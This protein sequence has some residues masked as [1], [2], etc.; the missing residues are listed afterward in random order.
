MRVRESLHTFVQFFNTLVALHL[1]QANK[2][3]IMK[4]LVY[5]YKYID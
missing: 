2:C 1:Q 4:Q 5:M 3:H